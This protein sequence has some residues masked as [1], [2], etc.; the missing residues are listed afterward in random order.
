MRIVLF[1]PTGLIGWELARSLAPLGT[2]KGIGRDRIDWRDARA[3]R[4]LLDAE[5]P[6]VIVNA[7]AYTAVDRAEAE[8]AAALAD[9][10]EGPGVLAVEAARTGAMLVHYST[11]YVFDGRNAHPYR[12]DDATGPL[13]VYGH[14]KLEGEQRV[15]KASDHHVVLRTSWVYGH[16]RQNF[17][18]TMLRLAASQPELRVVDDQFGA[19]TWS[20]H[21]A[22]ATAIAIAR[23]HAEPSLARG[24]FH[25]VAG[26]A[27][28]WHGFASAILKATG[29]NIP[30]VPIKTS[31]MPRPAV[32]PAN[33]RL[34]AS[35]LHAVLG[36]R[37]PDWHVGL[38]QCLDGLDLTVAS[39]S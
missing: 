23:W 16:R 39:R 26:G 29:S 33:S 11:D 8:P 6:D 14:T 9:N 3:V 12:E 20:R 38:Q 24:V 31:E 17:L 37:L 32:R 30:V 10:A 18:L 25:L 13:S 4:A 34:E 28:S 35:R 22:A 15:I 7:A 19:P 27:T 1:G 36:I 2:V 21:I 5:Q